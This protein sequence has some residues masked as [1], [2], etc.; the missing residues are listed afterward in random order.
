MGKIN[1]KRV[2]WFCGCGKAAELASP[3]TRIPLGCA[4]CSLSGRGC[5]C[6]PG[7]APGPGA[8]SLRE[9][10]IEWIGRQ[11]HHRSVATYMHSTLLTARRQHLNQLEMKINS[12][13]SSNGSLP[14][15]ERATLFCN[16]KEWVRG[17]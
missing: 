1:L 10:S 11:N 2:A 4:A 17:F 3:R 7:A 12:W 5:T 15:G 13:L 6:V 16:I 14:V 9:G 8:K